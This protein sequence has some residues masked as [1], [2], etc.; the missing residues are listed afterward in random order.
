MNSFCLTAVGNL[1]RSPEWLDEGDVPCARFCLVGNDYAG[2][3]DKGAARVIVT[4]LW[5]VAF[6]AVGAAIARHSQK[7]DQ[8][9]VEARVQVDNREGRQGEKPYDHAFIVEGFRFGAPSRISR[10]EFV[11]K[12]AMRPEPAALEA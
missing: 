10:E 3:D 7:G 12:R 1:A 6:G 9:I 5:F 4:S 8:L 11:E 2:K